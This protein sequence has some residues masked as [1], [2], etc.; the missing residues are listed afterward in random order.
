MNIFSVVNYHITNRCN[1]N[2]TYCFGKFHEQKDPSSD[3]AKRIIDNIASYFAQNQITDGRINLAG[4]E[5]TLYAHLNEVIDYASSLGIQ[6]SLVTNGSLLT[7][8]CICA[9]RDKV[10]CIGISI[11]SAVH[12]TNV[13]IGRC[14]HQNPILGLSHWSE[15]ANIIRNCNIDLKINTVVSKLNLD[16]DLSKF[17]HALRPQKIKLLQM[18]LIDGIN[19][20]ARPYQITAQEFQNFC[21]R[22]KTDSCVMVYEPN[23]SMENSYLMINPQ[24]EFQLNNHGVYQTFGDLK[25]TPLSQI[26]KKV[27]LDSEKFSF[28]YVKEETNHP[29]S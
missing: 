6:V 8:E 21:N 19:D 11:D 15:I 5:P 10:S 1:Y 2:C 20:Q 4:G 28:R 26:L 29:Q 22:H 12:D 24:G 27:P 9:W 23:E 3:E 17:Y 14:C 18:H 7:P 13:A 16:E 25:T